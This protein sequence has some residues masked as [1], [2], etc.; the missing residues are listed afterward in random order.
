MAEP[1]VMLC[2]GAQKAG[3]TWLHRT[4]ESHPECH[5]RSVKEIHYFDTLHQGREDYY[6]RTR[7][8]EQQ[9]LRRKLR[10]KLPWQGRKQ[11]RRLRDLREVHALWPTDDGH[12][13]AYAAYL[14]GG[15]RKE[16]VVADI[17][18][19]YM[20]LDRALFEQMGTVADDVRFV[21]LLRDPLDRAWSQ[22]RMN[23]SRQ[24]KTDAKATP[25][26]AFDRYL[27]GKNPIS[28]R[29]ADYEHALTHLTATVPEERRF[30]AFYEE[31]FCDETLFRLYDFLGISRISG[32]YDTVAHG[33]N[34]HK[35]DPRRRGRALAK[36]RPQYDFCDRFFE[37]RLPE[38]WRARMEEMAA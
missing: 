34:P 17:S 32:F 11:R 15:R 28:E 3:T 21:L 25:E 9:T 20:T 18:P 16:R 7:A 1:V 13:R 12:H 4:L 37:G 24:K 38:R 10:W 36:L 5:L 22:A 26:R 2:I 29:L 27:N 8:V 14:M 35:L 33:G 30:I 23:A 6:R 31:L 19:S